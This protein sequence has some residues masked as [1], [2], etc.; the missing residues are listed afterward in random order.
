[1]VDNKDKLADVFGEEFAGQYEETVQQ[2][3]RQR[4]K[5]DEETMKQIANEAINENKMHDT[6]E[7]RFSFTTDE[8]ITHDV[9][10]ATLPKP[11]NKPIWSHMNELDSGAVTI[12]M[13]YLGQWMSCLFNDPDDLRDMEPGEMYV[14][15]GKM[16]TWQPED[17][18]PRDQMSPV[19]GVMDLDTINEYAREMMDDVGGLSE[20]SPEEE[21]E[22]D[23]DEEDDSSSGFGS[24][25]SDDE[26]DEDDDGG[27]FFG[28]DDDDEEDDTPEV[29]KSE[30]QN[31]IEDT[32]E[33]HPEVWEA[34][35]SDKREKKVTQLVASKL[36]HDD[37]G[38][39]VMEQ[40]HELAVE[41]I[42]EH[43]EDDDE[44]DEEDALF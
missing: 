35:G 34:V 3:R 19:R 31:V 1:M 44:D 10:L 9:I 7:P 28:S 26:E 25:S 32:A 37:A 8:G 39:D 22:E 12:P 14:L 36:G 38:E 42:N 30:V 24:S 20:E 16:D 21:D 15:I 17:G 41:V 4:E 13:D 5:V 11:D 2:R 40:I 43:N 18:E 33:N 6:D 27:S 23:E 29:E